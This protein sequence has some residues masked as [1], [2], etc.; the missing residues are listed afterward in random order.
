V[1]LG[2]F[3]LLEQPNTKTAAQVFRETI[4]QIQWAEELGYDE[5]WLAEHHFSEYGIGGSLPVVAG[6]VA[7]ETT[8]IRIGT[9]VSILPFQ[10]P[11]HLA[12]DWATVDVLSNGRLDIGLGR[13]YQ[14]T[15]FAGFGVG[16]SDATDRFVESIDIMRKAWTEDSFSYAGKVYQIDQL[17]VHPRP[18]QQ[19]H[20][21]LYVAALQPT[22]YERVGRL[23]LGVLAAPLITPLEMIKSNLTLYREALR[24]SGGQPET[25]QY[26]MQQMVYVAETNEEAKRDAAPYFEWYFRTISRLIAAEKNEE[27]ADTYR[28]YKKSQ[29]HLRQIRMQDLWESR[30]AAVG[31]PSRVA[32]VLTMI[33]AELGMTQLMAWVGVGGMPHDKVMRSMEL[34]K[35]E[36]MPRVRQVAPGVSR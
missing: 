3:F 32:D 18:V 33:Q 21:P 7:R 5:V 14:P 30:T 13:G 28:F 24:Q 17:A 25:M 35:K 22:S 6:A 15:E 19:P 34:L 8:R 16:M 27:V 11:V 36:V 23:G 9:A 31:D 10:H 29:A 12:E 4:E 26:P 2:A 1:K 20:P